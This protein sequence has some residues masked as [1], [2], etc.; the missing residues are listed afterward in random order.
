MSSVWAS[1]LQKGRDLSLVELH[2][3]VNPY[4]LENKPFAEIK[5]SHS[6]YKSGELK[7]SLQPGDMQL[8]HSRISTRDAWVCGST[9]GTSTTKTGHFRSIIQKLHNK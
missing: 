8:C 4:G 2:A 7:C 6:G 1:V 9:V 5:D 3:Y